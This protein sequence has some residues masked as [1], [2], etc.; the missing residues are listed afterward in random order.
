MILSIHRHGLDQ[1]E[2]GPGPG[3]E[4]RVH[5]KGVD[6]PS[7]SYL[8]PPPRP[9][10]QPISLSINVHA[11]ASMSADALRMPEGRTGGNGRV[12]RGSKRR[13]QRTCEGSLQARFAHS[14]PVTAAMF[15]VGGD[16]ESLELENEEGGSDC[17]RRMLG[18]GMGF[19]FE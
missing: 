4:R 10:R 11:S 14:H 6:T 13:V 15:I 3:R 18:L 1:G 17:C 7:R 16:V 2:F 5:K 12:Y 9:S 19:V 8:W